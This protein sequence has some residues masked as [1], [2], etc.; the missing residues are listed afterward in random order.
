MK[1][2]PTC[3]IESSRKLPKT[4]KDPFWRYLF[5]KKL[6]CVTKIGLETSYGFCIHGLGI[7]DYCPRCFKV[8][9]FKADKQ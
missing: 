3:K 9:N 2:C 6:R 7:Y 8:F 1:F 4:D 5:P